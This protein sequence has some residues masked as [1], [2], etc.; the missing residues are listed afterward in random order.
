MKRMLNLIVVALIFAAVAGA[1]T[2]Y[3]MGATVAIISAQEGDSDGGD[4]GD[5]SD[6][7]GGD[8][9]DDSGG[10]GDDGGGYGGGDQSGDDGGGDHVGDDG[11]AG[12]TDDPSDPPTFEYMEGDTGL[13]MFEGIV[14]DPATDMDAMREAGLF[15]DR[16][17]PVKTGVGA[18]SDPVAGYFDPGTGAVF[19]P[20]GVQYYDPATGQFDPEHQ[21]DPYP[22]RGGGHIDLASDSPTFEY[23]EGDSGLAMFEGIVFDPAKDMDAM[24]EAGLFGDRPDPV[25]TGEGAPSDPVAGYFEPSTGK[26]FDPSGVQFYDPNTGLFYDE[27]SVHFFDPDTGVLVDRESAD[28]SKGEITYEFRSEGALAAYDQATSLDPGDFSQQGSDFS[29]RLAHEMDHRGFRDLGPDAVLGLFEAMDHDQ[30]LG[31][32]GVQI[33]GMFA[34]MDG[35]NIQGFDPGDVSAIA[36]GM[37]GQDF[38]HLDSDSAFGMF[39][40][41]GIDQSLDLGA[42][43]LAG[44]IN[45]FE[46]S[47]FNELGG[48]QVSQIA[49]ALDRDHLAGLGNK[50]ALGVASALEESG[51]GGLESGQIFGL[52]TAIDANDIGTLGEE[53]LEIIAGGLEVVDLASLDTDLAGEIFEK[54]SDDTLTAFDDSRLEAAL[55][56]LDANFFDAGADAFDSITGG[57]TTFDQ[58]DFGT[59]EVL[60]ELFEGAALENVFGGNLFGG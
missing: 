43:S 5:D 22:N 25:K 18:P 21:F 42:E 60:V 20:S 36:S 46:P 15:G 55:D 51:F 31:L 28:F 9:G 10:G 6:S 48:E 56:S 19:D 2:Q 59:P 58:I 30:V 47:H 26:V 17:D 45:E 44:M 27:H 39:S 14:F 3:A 57:D 8:H 34:A 40:S 11:A 41:M 12:H 33:A 53:V 24:R 37:S 32:E 7:D 38:Q 16:P 50:Q 23:M 1:L 13:A 52:T 54:V 35:E 49:G 4:H 29:F